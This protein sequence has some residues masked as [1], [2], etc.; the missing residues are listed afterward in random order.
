MTSGDAII[1]KTCSRAIE[2]LHVLVVLTLLVVP[3]S[4]VVQ[5]LYS[6]AH[7]ADAAQLSEIVRLTRWLTLLWNTVVVSGIALIT[8]VLL[9][10][11]FGFL[12]AR[13]N[14]PGAR[15][16][17]LVAV[18]GACMPVYVSTVFI[19][20]VIS[21]WSYAHSAVACGI[22]YGLIYSPLATV[23][24][25]AVFRAADRDI[26]DQ[27]RLDASDLKVLPCVT[28]PHAA[29]GVA[30][31]GLLIALLVAADHSLAD[32]LIVRTF[33]EEVYTQYALHGVAAGPALSSF[34]VMLILAAL[35]ILIQRRYRFFGEHSPWRFGVPPREFSLGRLRWPAFFA[36]LALAGVILTPPAVALM[37]RVGTHA[38]LF[39]TV[40]TLMTE[41]NRSFF[42]AAIGAAV[43]VIF[44]V[45]LAWGALRTRRLRWFIFAA[46]VIPLGLPAPVVGIGLIDLLNRPGPLGLLFD[47]S[48]ILVIGYVARFLPV[49]VL[50]LIPA[51][52]RVPIEQE[53]AARVDGCTWFGV[54]R[55]VYWP[56]ML[57]A[58]AV[59]W[60]IILILCFGE[61]GAAVL[62]A[63]PGAPSAS[64]RAATLIHFGVY[65]DLAVL[66][67][68]SVA[69]ITIPWLLLA[70][71]MRRI[72][73]RMYHRST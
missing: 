50:L 10:S 19:F 17:A 54:Q 5:A 62:L 37:K 39:T 40:H 14:M 44:A 25:A 63:P 55:H 66:A 35:L 8:A 51:V 1:R 31:I 53:L 52:Q 70:L 16:F 64:V 11:I 49:G 4:V 23:A 21:L 38:Q 9:G 48:A 67:L 30:M 12:I 15:A 58:V 33:A 47:S 6:L 27:A 3:L 26:E 7:D 73:V 68:L 13:T 61:V 65:R 29:W 42:L 71:L 22:M 32:I 34:P 2:G 18:L 36:C 69:Y 72:V 24:L 60:L 56:A 28:L 46:I 59:V 43:V 57:N 41:V 20:S 45:G